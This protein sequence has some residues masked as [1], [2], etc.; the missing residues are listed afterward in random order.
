MQGFQGQAD[1]SCN[2][3]PWRRQQSDKPQTWDAREHQPAP[4]LFSLCGMQCC[5]GRR[6]TTTQPVLIVS[7]PTRPYERACSQ[8][9][10]VSSFYVSR[11]F[12]CSC[13]ESKLTTSQSLTATA[14]QP[15]P[16]SSAPARRRR[17]PPHPRHVTP[18]R[19]DHIGKT[20]LG[21]VHISVHAPHAPPFHNLCHQLWINNVVK[22]TGRNGQDL[23][24]LGYI[25]EPSHSL[26][27][28]GWSDR[29]TAV[30]I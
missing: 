4:S 16:T 17:P 13:L 26:S 24:N 25:T 28:A 18:R 2:T 29:L 1:E 14:F 6:P 5:T 19:S 12:G 9:V 20:E 30:Y 15:T 27:L 7:I 8:R 21:T 23:W 10:G 22:G 3:N 11:N